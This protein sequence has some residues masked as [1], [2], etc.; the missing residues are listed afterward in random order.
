[1]HVTVKEK[2]TPSKMVE[3]QSPGDGRLS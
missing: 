3:N 2:L 1:M